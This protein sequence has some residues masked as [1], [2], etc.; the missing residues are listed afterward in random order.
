M[1]NILAVLLLISLVVAQDSQAPAKL[2][3]FVQG[4]NA[5]A[6]EIRRELQKATDKPNPKSKFCMA[7]VDNPKDADAIFAVDAVV[8]GRSGSMASYTSS[9]QL[10]AS[11][12]KLLWS[13]SVGD[14]S[15]FGDLFAGGNSGI[16]G[17]RLVMSASKA[18]CK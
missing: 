13:N 11:D 15:K 2:K 14:G 8:N 16:S 9:A 5:T 18:V 17:S 7:L 12:G 3:V 10:T 1:K 6:N 4:N